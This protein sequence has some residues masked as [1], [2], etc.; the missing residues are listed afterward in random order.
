LKI[1]EG[2]IC[3]VPPQGGRKHPEQN[4]IQVDTSNILFICGGTFTGIEEIIRKRLGKSSIGF[5]NVPSVQDQENLLQQITDEDLIQFGMIP[6]FVGRLPI[7]IPLD[8]MTEESLVSIL[9]E[10]RNA[11]LKQYQK[12]CYYDEV[13][14]KFTDGA[15]KQIAKIALSKGTGARALRSV[16]ESFM[17]NLMF[18]MGNNKGKVLTVDEDLVQKEFE[19]LNDTAA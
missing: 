9:T 1:I 11:I 8:A 19:N 10:P 3:N 2:T 6:E 13:D 17:S 15:I 7:Q 16:V 18:D 5:S 12:L 14:L 4:Y